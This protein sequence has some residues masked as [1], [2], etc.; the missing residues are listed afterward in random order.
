MR[1]AQ[2]RVKTIGPA[3]GKGGISMAWDERWQKWADDNRAV[4]DH[5]R[6]RWIALERR[7]RERE[8]ITRT[9]GAQGVDSRAV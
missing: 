3:A 9:D 4:L 6:D 5:L 2:V 7:N 8:A 1:A